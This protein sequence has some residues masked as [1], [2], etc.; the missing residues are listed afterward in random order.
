MG[1]KRFII[2]SSDCKIQVFLFLVQLLKRKCDLEKPHNHRIYNKNTID[3][4]LESSDFNG[5]FIWWRRGEL[6]PCPKMRMR[7]L[8]RAQSVVFIPRSPASNDKGR[9]RVAS[10][11]HL[12]LKAL[13]NGV[14][15]NYDAGKPLLQAAR[16]QLSGYRLSIISSVYIYA[17][18]FN[19]V[20]GTT[21]R[22][23]RHRHPRRNQYAPI[24]NCPRR[25]KN[26]LR[27]SIIITYFPAARYC[28]FFPTQSS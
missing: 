23:S 20:T 7:D 13:D 4:K 10:Y 25:H 6:N 9:S 26:S 16:P 18:L 22:L 21:A 24:F 1:S 8:L 15:C 11:L 14:P 2:K 27:G 19:V 17:R 3:F 5:V 28:L 12:T